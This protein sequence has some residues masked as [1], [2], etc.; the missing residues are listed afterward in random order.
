[1]AIL[2]VVQV[3][4][5]GVLQTLTAAGAGGD[6]FQ[7]TGR[8]F[9]AVRNAGG[10]SINVTFTGPNPDN[11]GVTGVSH[12]V[13][14]ACTN[15]SNIRIFGPFEPSRFNDANSRVQVTY[16]AVTTVTVNPFGMPSAA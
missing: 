8:E 14:A 12:D 3:T 5:A 15:D 13:V 1:M 4:K 2:A 10:A 11:W 7:N 16:S 9:F 6:S